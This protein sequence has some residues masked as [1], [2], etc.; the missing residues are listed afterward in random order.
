VSGH[1]FVD[2]N[3][4]GKLDPGEHGVDVFP[5]GLRHRANSEMDRGAILITTVPDGS[6]F[7]ENMY[8][9][10]QWLVLEAYADN[11]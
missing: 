9:L 8:P 10:N 6:Y 5:V 4:N 7:L 1:I 2:D 3:E 11:Y